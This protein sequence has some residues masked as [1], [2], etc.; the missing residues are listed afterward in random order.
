[1]QQNSKFMMKLS[2][3]ELEKIWMYE[4]LF[5]SADGGSLPTPVPIG[6]IFDIDTSTLANLDDFT[7]TQD[8]ST[9]I[10]LDGGY[11]KF[12]GTPA[13]GA[14]YPL[15]NR[16]TYDNYVTGLDKWTLEI[17]FIIKSVTTSLEGI[18]CG[19]Y[20]DPTLAFKRD[21]WYWQFRDSDNASNGDM[22]ISLNGNTPDQVLTNSSMDVAV[23]DEYRYT[24]DYN[25]GSFDITIQN[26][27]KSQTESGNRTYSYSSTSPPDMSSSLFFIGH[28]AGE[29]WVSRMKL[30][31]TSLKNVDYVVLGNSITQ[32]Y[33]TTSLSDRWLDEVKAANPLLTFTK[34]ACINDKPATVTNKSVEVNLINSQKA[35]IA[36][37]INGIIADGE[38]NTRI[39]YKAMTDMIEASGISRENFI[40]INV[41][42]FNGNSEIPIFNSWLA[43][44]YSTSTIFD[45]NTEFNDGSDFLKAIYDSGDGL[46]PNDAGNTYISDQINLLL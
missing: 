46:H 42:P 16:I 20:S 1:M 2:K 32:G 14:A 7:I 8:G 6:T 11:I 28:I 34:S 21:D 45:V 12:S 15:T 37:G 33:V 26:L 44:E 36:V 27:T 22:I 43:T 17:D 19:F 25:N 41:T 23:D 3:D 38:M 5:P 10:V 18:A 30:S 13:V 9:S 40:I 24:L 35:I 4:M 31:S 39:D 29:H